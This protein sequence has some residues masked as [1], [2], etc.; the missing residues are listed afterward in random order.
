MALHILLDMYYTMLCNLHDR[1]ITLLI[2]DTDP[3]NKWKSTK[4]KH[5]TM[6]QPNCAN[7]EDGVWMAG[8][9]ACVQV[10][11]QWHERKAIKN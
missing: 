11:L 4:E 2:S 8:T 7:S 1:C 10:G 6:E 5:Q 3:Q 9:M